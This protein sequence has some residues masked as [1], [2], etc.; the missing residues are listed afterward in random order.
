MGHDFRMNSK[1]IEKKRNRD[2]LTTVG[3]PGNF[4]EANDE[5][6]AIRKREFEYFSD[7]RMS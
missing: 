7:R 2:Y 3:L 5:K 4:N 1:T 6:W